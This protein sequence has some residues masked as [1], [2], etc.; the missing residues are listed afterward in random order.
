MINIEGKK[1]Y[2]LS[3][4]TYII[5]SKKMP[6]KKGKAL[7]KF[8]KWLLTQG[9]NFSEPLYFISLPE[10]VVEAA[11]KKLSQVEFEQK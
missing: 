7:V 9:Q 8:L 5:I 2:P 10:T 4:F 11:L 1:S 3:G 6:E